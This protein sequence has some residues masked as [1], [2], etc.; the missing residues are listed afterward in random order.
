MFCVL[1]ER[2]KII[3]RMDIFGFLENNFINL[4]VE[5]VFIILIGIILKMLNVEKE[6]ILVSSSY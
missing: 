5:W 6:F 4:I 2:I 3:W 1:V